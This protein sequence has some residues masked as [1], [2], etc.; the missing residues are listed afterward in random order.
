[1]VAIEKQVLTTVPVVPLTGRGTGSS[2]TAFHRVPE[3]F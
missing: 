2:T 3:R 1:M